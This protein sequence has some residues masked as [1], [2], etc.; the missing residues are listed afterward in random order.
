MQTGYPK[1]LR[2]FS[3]IGYHRYSLT[4]CTADR[5]HLF[6]TQEAVSL[7]A[8]QILRAAAEEAFAVI[9]YCFMPDHLHLVVEG[10]AE[11]SDLK[12]FVKL[13]KQFSAYHYKHWSGSPLWQRYSYEHVIRH[14]ESFAGKVRY[15]LENPVRAQLV[16]SPRDHP[17]LGSGT[18]TLEQLF[19]F[20]YGSR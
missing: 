14:D 4:F 8:S 6:I 18:Y 9:A 1:H 3:Y 11:H 2:G 17:F 13:A 10:A 20:A 16:T 19:D 7:V 5:A 15:V 12:R